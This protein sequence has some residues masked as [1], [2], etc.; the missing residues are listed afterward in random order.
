MKPVLLSTQHT[1]SIFKA[2]QK[3]AEKNSLRQTR[4]DDSEM[5]MRNTTRATEQQQ[6]EESSLHQTRSYDPRMQMRN[7]TRA[8][9]NNLLRVLP[10]RDYQ[11]RIEPEYINQEA[12]SL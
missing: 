8:L 11:A 6:T 4:S 7:T 9:N 12:L 3:Q 5:Q 1:Q 2:A 10:E